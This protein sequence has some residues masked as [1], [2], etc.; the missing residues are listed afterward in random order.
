[1]FASLRNDE[2]NA[3]VVGVDNQELTTDSY[4]R[5]MEMLTLALKLSADLEVSL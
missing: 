5:L 1:M 3:V 4:I 2:K